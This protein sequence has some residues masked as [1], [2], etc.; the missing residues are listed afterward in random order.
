MSLCY[1]LFLNK[2]KKRVQPFQP[3]AHNFEEID[4]L[5]NYCNTLKNVLHWKILIPYKFNFISPNV[6]D[7]IT[8][9]WMILN[10]GWWFW[11]QQVDRA[12]TEMLLASVSIWLI[13]ARS[14]F[15]NYFRRNILIKFIS[16][17][18]DR[19]IHDEIAYANRME[20]AIIDVEQNKTSLSLSKQYITDGLKILWLNFI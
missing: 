16:I 12:P 7:K 1:R 13:R 3:L 9:G 18:N 4:F 11:T 20:N 15:L 8:P 10:L 19:S 5:N 14:D 2:Q 17:E 6:E